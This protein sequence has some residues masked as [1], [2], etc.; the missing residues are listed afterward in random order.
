MKY[1]RPELVLAALLDKTHDENRPQLKTPPL[2]GLCLVHQFAEKASEYV[3]KN[4]SEFRPS[5]EDLVSLKL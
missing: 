5:E 1:I 2:L 3:K 4:F